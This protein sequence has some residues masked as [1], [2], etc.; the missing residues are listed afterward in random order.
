V[1]YEIILIGP[2]GAGKS[3]QAALLS[4]RLGVPRLPGLYADGAGEGFVLD[5]PPP[6]L[7]AARALNEALRRCGR[8]P[9]VVLLDVADRVACRRLAGWS[10]RSRS[11]A[12]R[13]IADHH[14]EIA[15]LVA[16][17]GSGH[18]L[19][20]VDAGG[21]PAAVNEAILGALLIRCRASSAND[22]AGVRP[23]RAM[24]ALPAAFGCFDR[25]H[26]D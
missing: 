3:T 26:D 14:R 18:I 19:H 17:Y 6:G 21:S 22:Q 7:S 24:L 16:F 8:Q 1:S 15:P 4:E 2:P 9:D 12:R 10:L 20:R 13:R 5:G 11:A 23:V 25:D